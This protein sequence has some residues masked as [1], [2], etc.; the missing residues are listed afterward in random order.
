MVEILKIQKKFSSII[1]FI[2]RPFLPKKLKK[3]FFRIFWTK[4][5]QIRNFT[6]FLF[7]FY[8]ESEFIL[9]ENFSLKNRLKSDKDL[10]TT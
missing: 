1:I 10:V 8:E 7:I 4:I 3:Q 5:D 2:K 9:A 6:Y